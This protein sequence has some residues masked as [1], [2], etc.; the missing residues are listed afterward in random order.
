MGMSHLFREGIVLWKCP[1]PR[2]LKGHVKK[3]WDQCPNDFSPTY[4]LAQD[5]SQSLDNVCENVYSMY[6]LVEDMSKIYSR[7]LP[8][9]SYVII[10]SYFYVC[11]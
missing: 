11:H 2:R 7:H 6:P 5:M 9:I 8:R 3:A 10:L 1:A 4:P